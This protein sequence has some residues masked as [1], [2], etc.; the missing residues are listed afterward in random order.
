[1]R[2]KRQPVRSWL[3]ESLR[4]Q[5]ADVVRIRAIMEPGTGIYKGNTPELTSP[6]AILIAAHA[7]ISASSA[8]LSRGN[9]LPIPRPMNVRKSYLSAF[10]ARYRGLIGRSR[11]KWGGA[12]KAPAPR[13]PPVRERRSLFMPLVVW[14]LVVFAIVPEGFNY[15]A[16]YTP[17]ALRIAVEGSAFSRA[18][19]L[20]LLGIGAAVSLSR[21]G[22]VLNLLRRVNPYLLVFFVLVTGS[23]LWSI[24]P[25]ITIR[26]L[27]RAATVTLVGTAFVVTT[28]RATTFQSVLRPAITA[29]LVGSIIFVFTAPDLAIHQSTQPEL[30]GAWHGLTLQK[31]SLGSLAAIGFIF[32]WHARLSGEKPLWQCVLGI[33]VSAICLVNS[34]SSTSLMAA[35]F[36]CVLMLL[37]LRSPRG[38]RRYLPYLIAIF[39]GALLVYSLAVL[40]LVPGSDLLLSPISSITG[41]DQ[42]FSGRTA[43]WAILNEH[44]ALRPFLGSGYGAYWVQV[45][46]SPSMQMLQRL[47]FYPTEGHNGYLDIINDLGFVGGLCLLGYVITYLRQGLMIFAVLRPQ[48]ALYLTLMFDQL[49][50]NLS[51][52]RW[53]NVLCFDFVIMTIATVAMGRT[54]LDQQAQKQSTASN[55]MRSGMIGNRRGAPS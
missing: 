42:T 2:V 16:P 45:P 17:E 25:E 28:W 39:I 29:L 6:H 47:Y 5:Q 14:V 37:L 18:I 10:S 31:N 48:G 7:L 43:I 51:E 55:R 41:K 23:I 3:F 21:S 1:M 22:I 34:R 26:R 40:N 15:S 19:W 4:M 52:S 27:V 9:Q 35:A 13:P 30:I 36:S 20:A 33:A 32:W 24:E 53:F 11:V 50:G 49:I 38:L 12:H 54:L 44:I 8:H 46:N